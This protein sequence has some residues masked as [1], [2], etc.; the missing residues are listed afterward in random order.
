[1]SIFCY[2]RVQEHDLVLIPAYD[3]YNLLG[4]ENEPTLGALLYRNL[5]H[6]LSW[7]RESMIKDVPDFC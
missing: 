5:A 2:L 7:T 6:P 1:M 3:T 4:A